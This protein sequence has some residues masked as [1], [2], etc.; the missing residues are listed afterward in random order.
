M[1]RSLKLVRR[2]ECFELVADFCP[3]FSLARSYFLADHERVS[4]PTRSRGQFVAVPRS[5]PSFVESDGA[6]VPF[7]KTVLLKMIRR[8]RDLLGDALGCVW[9]E[10]G[11]DG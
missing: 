10:G 11:T 6:D 7:V 4:M 1:D 9:F 2:S 5:R 8:V 3:S